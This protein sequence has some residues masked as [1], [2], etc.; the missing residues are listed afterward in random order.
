MFAKLKSG[1]II[2][3]ESKKGPLGR[4]KSSQEYPLIRE[5]L[6]Q[7][8]T[9]NEVGESDLLAVVVP[10]STKFEE[11]ALRWREAPFIKRCGILILTINRYNEVKGFPMY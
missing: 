6:G 8:I 11:L 5:A 2:R 9:I 4:S 7:I 3:A 1:K 10:S